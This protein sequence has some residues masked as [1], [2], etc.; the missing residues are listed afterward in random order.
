MFPLFLG[1]AASQ[2]VYHTHFHIVPRKPLNDPTFYD[3][4]YTSAIAYGR[5]RR[6]LDDRG[7]AKL[8]K[9]IRGEIWKEFARLKRKRTAK[10]PTFQDGELHVLSLL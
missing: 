6:D 4:P 8:A 9:K 2:V 10:D 3:T 5:T 1:A 7:G